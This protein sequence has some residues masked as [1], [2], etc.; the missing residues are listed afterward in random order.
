MCLASL[1]PGTTIAQNAESATSRP[2][3]AQTIF[4]T[5]CG[6]CHNKG[7]RE[8]G[9]GPQLMN[10][11]L[12][13]AEIITRIRKGKQGSMPSFEGAFTDEELNGLVAYIRALKP[14]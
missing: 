3:D 14:Q 7:G 12:S 4:A 11:T 5:T 1:L 10:T 6:W 2:R 8:A 9:K 13:D